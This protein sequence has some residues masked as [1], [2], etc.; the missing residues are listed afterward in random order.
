VLTV[1]DDVADQARGETVLVVT[2][3]GVILALWG[4]VAPGSPLG[5]VESRV[6]E[7]SAYVFER[8]ADGWRP[9]IGVP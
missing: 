9:A 2:H 3:G 8:D 7:T 1:L 5:P 4:A 6:D